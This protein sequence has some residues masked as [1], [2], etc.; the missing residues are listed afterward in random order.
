[1]QSDQRVPE[2]TAQFEK[3]GPERPRLKNRVGGHPGVC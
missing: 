3:S 1:M 2:A